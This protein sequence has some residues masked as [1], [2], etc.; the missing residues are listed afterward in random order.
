MSSNA[1]KD[2]IDLIDT[3]ISVSK[4]QRVAIVENVSEDNK[5][6]TVKF[7]GSSETYDFY[8]K[9]AEVLK[10][11]ESCT[12]T[13]ND[14]DLMNGFVSTRFGESSW[15][16][17]GK[18]IPISDGAVKKENLADGSVTEDKIADFS[19][20]NA[21]I[22]FG[23]IDTANIRKA[24]IET[25]LI[26]DAAITNAKIKNLAVDNA[27]IAIAAIDTANIKNLAVKRACIDLEAVGTSQVADASITDGK[28]VSLTA[29]KIV[30]GT[31][32][33]SKVTVLGTNGKLRI[34]NNRLQ[35]FDNQSTP[36]ER[37][38]LGDVNGDGTIYGFRVRGAD[39]TTTLID[40]TGVKAEGITNGSIS[41]AKISGTANIEGAKLLDNSIAG[42][43]LVVDAITAR[44]IAA[45]TITANE[46]LSNTITAGEIKAGTLTSASGIFGELNANEVTITNLSADNIS[47][48][49][50]KI[51]GYNNVNG[52]ISVLNSSNTEV[53]A[54]NQS[55]ILVGQGSYYITDTYGVTNIVGS[56]SN[57]IPDSGFETFK[58]GSIDATYH[59]SNFSENNI[60][61]NE[62]RW[63]GANSPKIV[64]PSIGGQ[65][66]VGCSSSNW[67]YGIFGIYPSTTYTIS[68]F[69]SPHL[70][71][72]TLSSTVG[73]SVAVSFLDLNQSPISTTTISGTLTYGFT[74]GATRYETNNLRR[75][76]QSIYTPSNARFIKISLQA[77]GISQWVVYDN[78]QLVQGDYPCMYTENTQWTPM[79]NS[80]VYST[81]YDQTTYPSGV[82]GD[83]FLNRSNS[84]IYSK[85]NN[86]WQLFTPNINESNIYGYT[87]SLGSTGGY[88]KFPGGMIYQWGSV[89]SQ[90]MSADSGS[91]GFQKSI[92]YPISFTYAPVVVVA[93]D[94]GAGFPRVSSR[95]NSTTGVTILCDV[96]LS[97]CNVS[98]TA[99]GW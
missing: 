41:N 28:I 87:Q 33:T 53:V 42:G 21:K 49:T 26:Q 98:W 93:P 44:E 78:F 97:G 76:V 19:V 51:G 17:A 63:T 52:T 94:Y 35:V 71:R 79:G 47:G 67:V 45:K 91:G 18:E 37:V 86:S 66:S 90:T 75:I 54:I 8:N 59:D 5:T 72:N 15:L 20:T 62:N 13:S 11:G 70:Y 46:I 16:V 85:T 58:P 95:Y 57:F 32:D 34:A 60:F 30:S 9:S 55:G 64:S 38:S 36:I 4:T 96:S 50:L 10:A 83:L 39:G 74:T 31:I 89:A 92:S 68:F 27:K 25:A 29:E 40:E 77:G 2:L 81:I 12:V 56:L 1:S 3:R 69:C 22:G 14:G 82:N 24:S 61:V 99:T 65:V 48:G 73:Y 43:K 84:C 88:R 80:A 6:I 23:E 7:P